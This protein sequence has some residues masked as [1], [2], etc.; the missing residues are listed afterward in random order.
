[1]FKFLSILEKMKMNDCLLEQDYFIFKYQ[2]K[3]DKVIIMN[4]KY[5]F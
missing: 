3:T 5:F 2:H 4:N 1:M